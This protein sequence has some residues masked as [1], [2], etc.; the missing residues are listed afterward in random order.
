MKGV[1]HFLRD[2]TATAVKEHLRSAIETAGE[3]PELT[4]NELELVRFMYEGSFDWSAF[5]AGRS[6]A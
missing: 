2:F 5:L 4:K 3:S 1:R 6:R